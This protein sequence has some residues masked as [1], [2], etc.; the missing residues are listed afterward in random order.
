M[1]ITLLLSTSSIISLKTNLLA[2]RRKKK[3][4]KHLKIVM[5]LLITLNFILLLSYAAGYITGYLSS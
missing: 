1:N 5:L 2:D 3:L 4:N